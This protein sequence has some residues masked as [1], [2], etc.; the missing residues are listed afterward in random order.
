LQLD[1]A[2]VPDRD[3]RQRMQQTETSL[4]MGNRFEVS[5]LRCGM[6]PGLQ[7]FLDRAFGVAGRRQVIGEE[8]RLALD[9]IAEM[10]IQLVGTDGQLAPFETFTLRRPRRDQVRHVRRQP[11][12]GSRVARSAA[13][14][15]GAHRALKNSS[16]WDGKRFLW[17][18]REGGNKKI[19]DQPDALEPTLSKEIELGPESVGRLSIWENQSGNR[20]SH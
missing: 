3:L 9:E 20:A 11:S 6:L 5:E 12:V 15:E 17:R 13:Q 1:F 8:F 7:P 10:L 4:E 19:R 14:F 2:A 16:T 18:E